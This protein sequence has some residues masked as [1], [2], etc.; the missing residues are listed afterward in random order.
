MTHSPAFPRRAFAAA[1][2]AMAVLG[3]AALSGPAAGADPPKPVP[4]GGGTLAIA[5]I[6]ALQVRPG[7]TEA[8][9]SFTT[10]EPTTVSVDY[11][12]VA[13]LAASGQPPSRLNQAANPLGQAPP[14]A[15][16]WQFQ[17]TFTYATAHELKLAG[18][19]SNTA[20]VVTVTA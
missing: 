10:A 16:E 8:A 14:T 15:G 3:A 4:I 7:G 19:T 13:A 6:S 1:A 5:P 20:Y 9:V 18:L 17:A 11:K 2:L 12:P